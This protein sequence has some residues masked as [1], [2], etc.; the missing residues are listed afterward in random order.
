MKQRGGE[1]SLSYFS[2]VEMCIEIYVLHLALLDIN[3][4]KS[5]NVRTSMA[6]YI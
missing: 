2:Q 3:F 5:R 4:Q 1:E 6:K